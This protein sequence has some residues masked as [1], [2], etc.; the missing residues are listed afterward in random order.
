MK[1]YKIG[2]KVW[3]PVAE[4]RNHKITCNVCYGKLMVD[5]LLGNG[6]KV[7]VKCNH[8]GNGYEGPRGYIEEYGFVEKADLREITGVEIREDAIGTAI[9]YRS[10]PYVLYPAN[11]YGLIPERFARERDSTQFFQIFLMYS[12]SHQ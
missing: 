4:T 6:D 5:I 9:E 10:K 2:D 1:K 8:C 7:A 12:E 11:I 3:C